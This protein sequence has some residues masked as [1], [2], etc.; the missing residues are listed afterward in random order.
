[1][2]LWDAGKTAGDRFIRVGRRRQTA[3]PGGKTSGPL[4][5]LRRMRTK[6]I[7]KLVVQCALHDAHAMNP[8]KSGR[9]IR[10]MTDKFFVGPGAAASTTSESRIEFQ[11]DRTGEINQAT[12]VSMGMCLM[13]LT[14]ARWVFGP[15]P[16]AQ[17]DLMRC[18]RAAGHAC[19][20]ILKKW[21][22]H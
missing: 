17:A 1:M 9:C 2:R 14:G 7:R 21:F 19:H 12:P 11:R 15:R 10:P 16:T 6:G 22:F 13:V 20:A 8:A 18:P 4:S 3:E 5:P